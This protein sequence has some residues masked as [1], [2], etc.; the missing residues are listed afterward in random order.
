M[1]Y[2]I[3]KNMNY[4]LRI[5]SWQ[6]Q[7]ENIY[8]KLKIKNAYWH[9]TIRKVNSSSSNS[10][11][12]NLNTRVASSY[13]RV[14]S[15]CLKNISSHASILKIKI[16]KPKTQWQWLKVKELCCTGSSH[17]SE[18]LLLC[19]ICFTISIRWLPRNLRSQKIFFSFSGN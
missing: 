17:I 11:V 1:F 12:T 3:W 18:P 8:H 4:V 6:A 7:V 15:N 13:S 2:L 9:F 16:S 19:T 10:R 14:K 5:R